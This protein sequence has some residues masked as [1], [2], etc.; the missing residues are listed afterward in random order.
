MKFGKGNP[1]A[2]EVLQQIAL[3][4]LR[5]AEKPVQLYSDVLRV[6]EPCDQETEIAPG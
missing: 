4:L 1:Q 2:G 3:N 6:S 5:I